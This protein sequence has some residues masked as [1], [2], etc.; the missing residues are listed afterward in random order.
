MIQNMK[1]IKSKFRIDLKY[2]SQH[3][4]NTYRINQKWNLRIWEKV[5]KMYFFEDTKFPNPFKSK[6]VRIFNEQC[7]LRS[8]GGNWMVLFKCWYTFSKKDINFLYTEIPKRRRIWSMSRA[9]K[10]WRPI[11]LTWRSDKNLMLSKKFIILQ[12]CYSNNELKNG[13]K[14]FILKL[15]KT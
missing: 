6:S 11:F 5:Q 10:F 4:V 9:D 13:W 2:F 3:L 12:G 1:N 7:V 8:F 15:A 14:E